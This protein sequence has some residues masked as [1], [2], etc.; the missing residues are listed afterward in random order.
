MSE[1]KE[2]TAHEILATHVTNV[3]EITAKVIRR[4]CQEHAALQAVVNERALATV[5]SIAGAGATSYEI[6][7]LQKRVDELVQMNGALSA[8]ISQALN[9]VGGA[10]PKSN[11]RRPSTPA[12]R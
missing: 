7:E 10:C 8:S 1:E 12:Q 2:P 6:Q 3:P 11:G 5:T 4:A 9:R